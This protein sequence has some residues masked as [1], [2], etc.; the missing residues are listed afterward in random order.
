MMKKK[1]WVNLTIISGVF[2][3]LITG[4]R[5]DNNNNTVTDF[6]GN[7]YHTV[8]IGPQLWMVETLKTTHYRNGDPIPDVSDNTQWSNLT[9]G[10]YVRLT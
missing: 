8:T 4:Y 2:F 7:I 10:A 6:D 5:Q 3:I 1:D 9:T